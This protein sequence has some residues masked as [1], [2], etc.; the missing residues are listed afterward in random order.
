MGLLP[1]IDLDIVATVTEFLTV[2]RSIDTKLDTLIELQSQQIVDNTRGRVLAASRDRRD[3]DAKRAHT[4]HCVANT[5]CVEA[6]ERE[7]GEVDDATLDRIR[8]DLAGE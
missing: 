3:Q 4:A 7:C 8:R 6:V 2:L 1:K 5:C